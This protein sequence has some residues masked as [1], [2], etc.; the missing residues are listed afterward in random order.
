MTAR[1]KRW[2]RYLLVRAVKARELQALFVKYL[3]RD[4]ADH[5]DNPDT[6]R[7]ASV[8]RMRGANGGWVDLIDQNVSM[9]T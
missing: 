5:L 6:S 2:R 4:D 7:W 8:G 1:S 9:L 3:K